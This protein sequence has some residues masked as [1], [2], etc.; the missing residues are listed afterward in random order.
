VLPACR[1]DVAVGLMWLN[2]KSI[3]TSLLEVTCK[4]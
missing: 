1:I 3:E 4:T 2:V